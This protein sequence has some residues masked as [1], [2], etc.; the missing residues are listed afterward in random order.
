MKALSKLIQIIGFAAIAVLAAAMLS[1]CDSKAEEWSGQPPPPEV[2]VADVVVQQVNGWNEFNGRVEAPETVEIRPRVSGY[3]HEARYEEGREVAKGEVLFVIDQRPYRAALARSEA[4]LARAEAQEALASSRAARARKLLES[5]A[6]SQE[7]HDEAV[8]TDA[9]ASANVG[10]ARAALELA[11]LDLE[12]TEVRSPI[13]GVAGRAM[14]TEGNLVS[15]GE[16]LLTTVVS[17]DPAYVYFESDEQVFLRS[18]DLAERGARNT[19]LVGLATDE[20]FPHQGELDFV[21]NRVNPDTGTIRARA[22]LDNADRRFTPGLFAR[23]RLQSSEAQTAIL[24]DER[25]IL[26]DQ[27]R[28]FVYVLGEDDTA[29]RRDVELGKSV[30]GLR[31]IDSGLAA[32][33][34]VIVHGVQKIYF[35]GMQVH[36]RPIAMGEAAPSAL[37][38]PSAQEPQT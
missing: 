22:V 14:V 21:D 33:D 10:V 18:T 9:Q 26:T 36:A 27:D 37:A 15:A 11:R 3:I 35:P 23:V 38:V 24:I 1:A 30:D 4:E 13:A 2:S 6:I 31:I 16:S 5:R 28:R 8:A 34:R 32:G 12:F 7:E 20:G 19:V 25:A 29:Q 17:L